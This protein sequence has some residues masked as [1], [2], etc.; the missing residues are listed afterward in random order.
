M[1]DIDLATLPASVLSQIDS[2]VQ[3]HARREEWRNLLDNGTEQQ[4]IE[5]ERR[6]CMH[7]DSLILANAYKPHETPR[8]HYCPIGFLD[9]P[10]RPVAMRG[11]IVAMVM[12]YSASSFTCANGLADQILERFIRFKKVTAFSQ[13]EFDEIVQPAIEKLRTK[14][15]TSRHFPYR[16][17]GWLACWRY[18]IIIKGRVVMVDEHQ[19]TYLNRLMGIIRKTNVLEERVRLLRLKEAA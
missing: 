8:I 9:H 2:L 14:F 7:A 19:R 13:E 1:A 6:E 15:R 5:R 4:I 11:S 17:G 10:R 16:W 18:S 3:E 12:R